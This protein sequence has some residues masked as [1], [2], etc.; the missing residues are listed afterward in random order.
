MRTQW[1]IQQIL[2][3]INTLEQHTYQFIYMFMVF[4][5]CVILTKMILYLFYYITLFKTCCFVL[6]AEWTSI[7]MLPTN[8]LLCCLILYYSKHFILFSK[9]TFKLYANYLFSLQ[10]NKSALFY[11]I[12]FVICIKVF[13][14][15][16]CNNRHFIILFKTF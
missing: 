9:W 11:F 4:S 7:I 10:A 8:S 5:G 3:N 6:Y 12:L 1:L 16:L 13:H 15:M 14:I 2:V